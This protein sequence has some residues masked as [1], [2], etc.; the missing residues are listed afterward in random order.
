MALAGSTPGPLLAGLRE[1]RSAHPKVANR[2]EV[3]FAGPLSTQES[4][5]LSAPDLR[6]LV[7]TVGSLDRPR[8]LALQRSA[9][10]L[11]VITEGARRRSVA[12]GK[13]FEYLAAGPPILVL[14]AETEAARIVEEVG[15]GY[16]T[17]A[18]DPDAIAEAISSLVDADRLER[19]ETSVLSRYSWGELGHRYAAL[20]DSI[21][22]GDAT[23][24]PGRKHEGS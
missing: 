9:D 24:G 21:C 17:S 3:V 1:L 18:D 11:I 2:V 14:G 6:G 10:A 13:L 5:A 23:P 4:E 19:A 22:A 15:A 8:A 12:T 20:I 16:V 7:R